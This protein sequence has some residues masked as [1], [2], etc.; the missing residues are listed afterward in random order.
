MGGCC[1]LGLLFL[2]RCERNQCDGNKLGR[3]CVIV[4]GEIRGLQDLPL[5][6]T[7]RIAA[8]GLSL[9][10]RS[11][12]EATAV[13]IDNH[14]MWV[15]L[16]P[17][18]PELEGYPEA[19]LDRKVLTVIA[20]Y[21][22]SQ[23]IAFP[24]QATIAD[25]LGEIKMNVNRSVH[26][27]IDKR[28][29]KIMRKEKKYNDIHP[30][31]IYGVASDMVRETPDMRSSHF[32]AEKWR[33]I[34]ARLKKHVAKAVDN[35]KQ[36]AAGFAENMAKKPKKQRKQRS[37]ENKPYYSPQYKKA[38]P[39]PYS[40][41]EDIPKPSPVDRRIQD[42]LFEKGF[43]VTDPAFTKIGLWMLDRLTEKSKP[44]DYDAMFQRAVEKFAITLP[45][46]SHPVDSRSHSDAVRDVRLVSPGDDPLGFN[47]ALGA[48]FA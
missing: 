21:A 37:S 4:D 7:P 34:A 9:Y 39:I 40:T 42:M 17:A 27:L 35:L 32:D 1:G 16:E 26:R 28:L 45:R 23:G 8:E 18:Y 20:C 43:Q 13:T 2:V 30:R 38:A 3:T 25:I 31:C 33:V 47:G 19:E 22:N 29:I 14:P 5:Y 12:M 15:N 11:I 24:L 6:G 36:V 10:G 44:E 41:G 48:A 46:V